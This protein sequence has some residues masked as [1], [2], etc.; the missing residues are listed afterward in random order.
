[1]QLVCFTPAGNCFCVE[2]DGT[3][4]AIVQGVI[5][6]LP[7]LPGGRTATALASTQ[8]D[9]VID[10]VVVTANDSTQWLLALFV[11]GTNKIVQVA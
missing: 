8:S 9:Q 4:S 5:K 7:G 11:N 2:G 6:N 10:L 3:L 1:M